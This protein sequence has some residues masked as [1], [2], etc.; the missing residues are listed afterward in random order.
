MF[1]YMPKQ[2]SSPHTSKPVL[3]PTLNVPGSTEAKQ[4]FSQWVNVHKHHSSWRDMQCQEVISSPP[5]NLGKQLLG[6]M[7]LY[8]LGR[9]QTVLYRMEMERL[10]WVTEENLLQTGAR[11]K[12]GEICLPGQQW[13]R[14]LWHG[15]ERKK[16]RCSSRKGIGQLF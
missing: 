16:V 5:A 8:S 2:K 10:T 9:C 12:K 14:W 1:S 4:P 13:T 3:S 11:G 7:G 15:S 6:Q